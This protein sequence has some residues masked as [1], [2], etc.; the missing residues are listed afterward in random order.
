MQKYIFPPH[1]IVPEDPTEFSD[2]MHNEYMNMDDYIY[3]GDSLYTFNN[4]DQ[5]GWD[6]TINFTHY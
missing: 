1:D 6:K 2:D 3:D 5:M 4:K